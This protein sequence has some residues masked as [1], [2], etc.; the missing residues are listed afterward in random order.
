MTLIL[1]CLSVREVWT[2]S[3]VWKCIKL[4]YIWSS[5]L[6]SFHQLGKNISP[7]SHNIGNATLGILL[8]EWFNKKYFNAKESFGQ[9]IC[10]NNLFRFNQALTFSATKWQFHSIVDSVEW[11]WK[12]LHFLLSFFPS[13]SRPPPKNILTSWFNLQG[14]DLG[15]TEATTKL[16]NISKN[17]TFSFQ[18]SVAHSRGSSQHQLAL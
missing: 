6:C 17:K 8:V 9:R 1:K 11:S 7:L 13:R 14:T 16:E 4:L 10:D 3:L 12:Y 5:P 18:P 15:S 2:S